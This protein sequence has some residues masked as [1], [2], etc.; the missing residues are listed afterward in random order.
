MIVKMKKRFLSKSLIAKIALVL[1]III[2]LQFSLSEPVRAASL[3]GTL[4]NPVVS[5]FVFLAD[6]VIQILQSALT[7]IEQS[8]ENIPLKSATPWTKIIAILGVFAGIWLLAA[9]VVITFCTG[10]GGAPLIVAAA[11]NLAS[12][13]AATGF[14]ALGVGGVYLATYPKFGSKFDAIAFGTEF[15]YARIFITPETILKNQIQLFNVNY[16][17]KPEIPEGQTE[18]EQTD[19]TI[20]MAGTL[21][22]VVKTVYRTIRD[23]AVI[24]MLIVIVYVGI[25]ML[26]AL[27]PKEKSRYKE[28]LWNCIIGFAIILGAHFIMVISVTAAE[29]ITSS[30]ALSTQMYDIGGEFNKENVE[31]YINSHPEVGDEAVSGVHLEIVGEE[32][33]NAVKDPN[34][35]DVSQYPGIELSEENGEKITRVQASNFTEQARYMAQK[36]YVIDEED[37]KT[38]TWEHI[39]WGFVYIMLVILTIAFIVMYIK[40]TG[41]MMVLTILAP[42]VGLMYPIN[43][44]NGSRAHTLNLWFKEY[45]GNLIIQPF[46]LILYSILIG[47][48]MS[49]AINN[50]IW[51]IG[52]IFILVRIEQLLK[53]LL[54]IQDT[55]IGSLGKSLQET[56][57]AIKTTEKATVSMAKSIG[58]TASRGANFL[59]GAGLGAVSSYAGRNRNG[60]QNAEENEGIERPVRAQGI[61]G[62]INRGL[63]LP[64]DTN[65]TANSNANENE[66]EDSNVIDVPYREEENKPLENPNS[67]AEPIVAK[68]DPLRLEMKDEDIAA[69]AAALNMEDNFMNLDEPKQDIY[70]KP[71]FLDTE[72]LD[73]VDELNG[74]EGKI[75][76]NSRVSLDTPPYEEIAKSDGERNIYR[77][78]NGNLRLERPDSPDA[79]PPMAMA[80]AAGSEGSHMNIGADRTVGFDDSLEGTKS[81]ANSSRGNNRTSALGSGTNTTSFGTSSGS[82]SIPDSGSTVRKQ[83]ENGTSNNPHDNM[84]LYSEN[85]NPQPSSNE[86]FSP[87]AVLDGGRS[88]NTGIPSNTETSTSNVGAENIR[89]ATFD[90]STNISTLNEGNIDARTQ[91]DVGINDTDSSITSEPEGIH[92]LTP[93]EYEERAPR[94]RMQ[95]PETLNA[96]E[97][98]SVHRLTPDEY[99]EKAPRRRKMQGTQSSNTSNT[100]NSTKATKENADTANSNSNSG[101][102]DNKGTNNTGKGSSGTNSGTSTSTNSR[103]TSN[104]G[105]NGTTTSTNNNQSNTRTNNT[106]NGNSGTSSGS[107]ATSN[108]GNNGTTSTNNNQSN[109]GNSSTTNNKNKDDN[110]EKVEKVAKAIEKGLNVAGKV[111]SRAANVEGTIAEGVLDTALN[112]VSGNVGGTIDTIAGTAVGVVGAVQGSPNYTSNVGASSK[113]SNSSSSNESSSNGPQGLGAKSQNVRTIMNETGM[114]EQD[115]RAFEELCRREGITDDR[116]MA[117]I[118][119]VYKSAP[120]SDKKWI[121]KI[122][123]MLHEMRRDRK[124]KNDAIK[125]LEGERISP[126]TK[127]ALEK[128]YEKLHA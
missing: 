54:G 128:M 98:E 17:D 50:P 73:M 34:N 64:G 29:L 115:A 88:S 43:K 27:T 65:G 45:M 120:E 63:G 20:S 97:L 117:R 18:E 30:I 108:S 5:L 125:A 2:L 8:F 127:E 66:E 84:Y 7:S 15:V 28:S 51:V 52:A 111:V 87:T 32:L 105:N 47:S 102:R 22:D 118:G 59:A 35:P 14:I 23:V 92:R 104:S 6:G 74:N 69:G 49:I 71:D 31:N 21:R 110:S 38:E 77:D 37:N 85:K 90:T 19:Q 106:G 67:S 95:K 56:T 55:R 80:M 41:Y 58:R 113:S 89:T 12:A 107:R 121:V 11:T 42:I 25:R 9:S 123:K 48:A 83:M 62:G 13:F 44:V 68:G 46:H 36:M 4:L 101:T 72:V 82:Q 94:R 100:G 60:Q 57:R 61:P 119:K 126:S 81:R 24:A 109:T 116:N 112:A 122:S 114:S 76:F 124:S 96:S 16:F 1:V 10:G 93:D 86:K 91:N 26:L 53:D 79:K 103:T 78:S 3:G 70:E 99:E 33:Y 39:G 40:R 75:N